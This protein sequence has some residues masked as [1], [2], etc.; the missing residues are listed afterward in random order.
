M[1]LDNCYFDQLSYWT[2]LD[3][4]HLTALGSHQCVANMR[5]GRSSHSWKPWKWH[6]DH[7]QVLWSIS[8]INYFTALWQI[9]DPTCLASRCCQNIRC[10][11]HTL[12]LSICYPCFWSGERQITCNRQY[13][14]PQNRQMNSRFHLGAEGVNR[15]LWVHQSEPCQCESTSAFLGV[16]AL[17]KARIHCQRSAQ[18]PQGKPRIVMLREKVEVWRN[19]DSQSCLFHGNWKFVSSF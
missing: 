8:R 19:K 9:T 14:A 10:F 7:W 12:Q 13:F 17:F 11:G 2:I 3:T 18:F 16:S 5:V 4:W 15:L 6:L 1:Q